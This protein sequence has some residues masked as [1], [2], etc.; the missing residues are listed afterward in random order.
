MGKKDDI[1]QLTNIMS[2]ALR[3]KIGSIVNENEFYAEKYAKDAENIMKEAE[4]VAEKQNWNR[5]DKAVIKEKL[6][7]KLHKELED[8][9]FI[10]NKKFSVM[11]EETTKALEEFNLL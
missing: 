5:D 9:D 1:D 6:R 2:K 7:K 10:D 3:H 8:K 4:R 11:D